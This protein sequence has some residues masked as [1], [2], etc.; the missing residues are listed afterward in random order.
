MCLQRQQKCANVTEQLGTVPGIEVGDAF[1]CRAE[2]CVVGLHHEF[3]AGIDS[4]EKEGMKIATSIVDSQRYANMMGSLNQFTYIGHGGNPNVYNGM[5]RDQKLQGGNL[6]LMNSIEAEE[7]VRVISIL[8]GSTDSHGKRLYTYMG[9]YL[10]TRMVQVRGEHGKLVFKFLLKREPGQPIKFT[11]SRLG[12]PAELPPMNV[13]RS[14]KSAVR[15]VVCVNDISNGKEEKP[16][17]MMVSAD[18]DEKLPCFD[19][20]IDVVYP[21]CYRQSKPCFCVHSCKCNSSCRA[22]FLLEIVKNK[23]KRWTVRTRSYIPAG[24]FV[25]EYIGELRKQGGDCCLLGFGLNCNGFVIDA[26]KRGNVARFINH[27]S[28]P[29]LYVGDFVYDHGDRRFPHKMLFAAKN[30]PANRELTLSYR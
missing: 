26:T 10:V 16:V 1:E 29:N 23:Y 9:L 3:Q 4:M 11:P 21:K 17:R 27:S 15:N 12:Q 6:A 18:D 13:I 5:P 7:P 30:I 14:Q 24:N 20:I 25:C 2:L 22:G 28:N 19:Y 8:G